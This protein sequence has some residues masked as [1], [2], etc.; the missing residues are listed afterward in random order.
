MSDSSPPK[1]RPRRTEGVVSEP[2]VRLERLG[3]FVLN[4]IIR[5]PRTASERPADRRVV[6]SSIVSEREMSA[7]LS[8]SEGKFTGLFKL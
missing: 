2:R 7:N 6:F 1:V 3:E 8:S 5:N 4:S